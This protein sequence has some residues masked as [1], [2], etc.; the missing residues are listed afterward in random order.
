MVSAV[1]AIALC[2]AM[3]TSAFAAG[4]SA[5]DKGKQ[6]LLALTFDDG[7]GPYSDMIMD[8]L[9]ARGAK[10]TFFMNGYLIKRYPN[11]VKRM[12]AD[13]FQVGNHTYDH[14][15]LAKCSAEKI[16]TEIASTSELITK[17]TGLKGTGATGF[18]LRPPYGSY[19]KDV[20]AAAGVPVIWCT[21]D[22]GDWKYDDS[23]RLV[24]YTSSAVRDGDI[25]IMHES[26]KSTALG[27]G[28][29]VDKLQSMGYELVTVQELLARRGVTAQA[30]KI[31]YSAPNK[32]INR[33]SSDLYFDETKLSSH[34]AYEAI[35]YSLKNGYMENNQYGEFTPNFPM[36]RGML[37]TALGKQAGADGA[38]P[39]SSGYADVAAAS[40]EAPYT[41]WAKQNGL[42][43]G[44]GGDKFAPDRSLTRQEMAVVLTRCAALKGKDTATT[45]EITYA[46]ASS[47][48]DW[49]LDGVKYCTAAGL[50]VGSGDKFMPKKTATR[51][52]GAQVLLQVSKMPAAD[53]TGA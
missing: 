7:P 2:A 24:S 12:A 4:G 49:A 20:I 21:V 37:V 25:V 15:F 16:K 29:L 45:E 22:S 26:H 11:A 52:M 36:T 8:T 30:G 6:K 19:N 1:I 43:Q 14:P 3:G 33:C 46:D 13:G 39:E 50:M 35:D 42:M 31:Y 38:A 34:W 44:I 40:P 17:L 18:Y 23:A 28:K 48:S 47:I 41:A 53:T 5:Y 27:L 10:A 32:G 51:A 9:E